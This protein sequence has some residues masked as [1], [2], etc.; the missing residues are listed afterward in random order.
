MKWI[1]VVVSLFFVLVLAAPSG[2][3]QSEDERST[4]YEPLSQQG[5]DWLI[6]SARDANVLQA[7]LVYFHSDGSI[8]GSVMVHLVGE[9]VTIIL[10]PASGW[11]VS[12]TEGL[13]QVTF[14]GTAQQLTPDGRAVGN[15][16]A[17][18]TPQ[19]GETFF[20]VMTEI[21]IDPGI[22]N[23]QFQ[24]E[25]SLWLTSDPCGER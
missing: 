21:F 25:G 16:T 15:F 2:L 11:S 5:I 23:L 1:G 19:A 4:F 6:L 17:V 8:R 24:A 13:S 9:E 20:D 12:C 18:V 3:V 10:Y 14:G 7:H 22:L